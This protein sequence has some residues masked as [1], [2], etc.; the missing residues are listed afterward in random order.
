[1]GF[2]FRLHECEVEHLQA[3]DVH[4]PIRQINRRHATKAF[5]LADLNSHKARKLTFNGVFWCKQLMCEGQGQPLRLRVGWALRLPG[6]SQLAGEVRQPADFSLPFINTFRVKNVPVRH[7]CAE[8][9]TTP[10]GTI[11][12]CIIPSKPIASW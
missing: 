8:H 7:R 11:N 12:T 5:L 3:S 10:Q 1:M 9:R 2:Y 6:S 4:P